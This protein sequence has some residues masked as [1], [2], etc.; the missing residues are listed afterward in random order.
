MSY[1]A[2]VCLTGFLLGALFGLV[3]WWAALIW[4]RGSQERDP[5]MIDV[6]PDEWT[7]VRRIPRPPRPP[8]FDYERERDF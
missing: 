3:L 6:P 1:T 7:N 2:V 5:R 8:L 4:W